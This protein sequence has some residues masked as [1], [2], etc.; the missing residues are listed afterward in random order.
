VFV[1]GLLVA[2]LALAF[3]ITLAVLQ[4]TLVSRG[5]RAGGER[6]SREIQVELGDA[7]L[8]PKPI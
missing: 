6:I 4:R 7:G 3:E 1:G 2:L 8:A 5:L